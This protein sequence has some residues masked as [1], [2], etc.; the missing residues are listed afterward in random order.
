V[1]RFC[2]VRVSFTTYCA[3]K[4]IYTKKVN[5]DEEPPCISALEETFRE[6]EGASPCRLYINKKEKSSLQR[7]SEAFASVELIYI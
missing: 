2:A 1:H 4:L 7:A 6:Q 3:N 5:G